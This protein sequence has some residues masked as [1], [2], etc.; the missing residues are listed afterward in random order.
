MGI[1]V[2]LAVSSAPIGTFAKERASD[3]ENGGGL[4][5]VVEPFWGGKVR[6]CPAVVVDNTAVGAAH[7]ELAVRAAWSGDL[8]IVRGTS[9]QC[10]WVVDLLDLR[11][12]LWL[13]RS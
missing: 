7:F 1:H 8:T 2:G 6:S 11:S 10:H 13:G 5:R 12:S 9:V 3:A 4:N